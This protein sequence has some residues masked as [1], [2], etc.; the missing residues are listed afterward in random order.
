MGRREERFGSPDCGVRSDAG[1]NAPRI[2]GNGA[3]AGLA[4]FFLDIWVRHP[5]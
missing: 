4:L 3:P 5:D 1:A 2:S